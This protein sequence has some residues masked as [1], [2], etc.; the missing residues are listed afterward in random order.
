M[1]VHNARAHVHTARTHVQTC[2][3]ATPPSPQSCPC[4]AKDVFSRSS[5]L[6]SSIVVVPLFAAAAAGEGAAGPLG[7]MYFS[8]D[9]PCDFESF[10]DVLLVGGSFSAGSS[11][12]AVV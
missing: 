7:G 12:A 2:Q 6:V 11:R 1:H 9:T 5:G 4:P 10:R 8:L 3:P